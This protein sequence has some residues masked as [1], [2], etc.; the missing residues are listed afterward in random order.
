VCFTR[1]VFERLKEEVEG[2]GKTEWRPML[3]YAA[4]LHERSVLPPEAPFFTR[5][6]E[7]IGPGYVYGPA[8]G[9]WDLVHAL[10]DSLPAEPEHVLAQLHNLLDQLQPDGYLP[11]LIWMRADR[12]RAQDVHTCPPVWPV[13][14]LDY[15]NFG[16][17]A[18]RDGNGEAL[19][20]RAYEAV[21]RQL[22]WF[23]SN[24]RSPDGGFYYLDVFGKRWESGVDEGVRFDDSPDEPQAC[25]DATSHL[26]MLN[27]Y[28]AELA[29]RT[30]ASEEERAAHE[31]R[32]TALRELI[33]ERLWD[34]QTGFFHDAWAVGQPQRRRMAFE[35]IFPLL[36][37][38]ATEEQVTRV[39]E[40]NLLNPER[41]F[42]QHPIST[43]ALS[44][45]KFER[46]MWRGP[47]W[48]SMTYW[49]ARG[50]AR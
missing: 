23:E 14:V 47:A 7:H 21:A 43:V 45:P 8:F 38:A 4:A 26:A 6:W 5:P 20:A 17:H 30:G 36:A 34:E 27:D 19:L 12:K 39:V 28:A 15:V 49:A 18:T 46:R 11:S 9:H 40:E 2:L 29:K 13:V 35:G 41:F 44:D 25:V 32:G 1:G 37:G 50:C 33:R 10:L 42:A 22:R 24:R 16:D 48:N 31:E 3:R